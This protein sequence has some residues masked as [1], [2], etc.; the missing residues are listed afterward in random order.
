MVLDGGSEIILANWPDDKHI[1]NVNN[2]ILVKIPSHLY[3][4]VNRS[5]LCN[6]SIE[7]ENNILLESLAAHHDSN[8]KLVMYFTVIT[9]FFNYL[10]ILD[11]LTL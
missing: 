8:S 9:A 2:D 1:C 7:A 11:N 3:A 5:V 6:C 10:D 4:L